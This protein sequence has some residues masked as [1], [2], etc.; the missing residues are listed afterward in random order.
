[1]LT[2][3]GPSRS[4]TDPSD[5]SDFDEFVRSRAVALGRLCWALTGDRGMGE[6]L[7][8]A[9]LERLWRRW[10]K[11][12]AAGDPWAYT[13]RIAATT[14]AS[15]R[16]RRWWHS[17]VTAP[18]EYLERLTP[19]GESLQD[20]NVDAWLSLLTVEQR[21][22]IVLRFLMDMTVEQTADI[23]RS[24]PGTI[25]S[26]TSR[27]LRRIRSLEQPSPTESSEL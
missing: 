3:V 15:W 2:V 23:L 22:V 13:C 27:A 11:V 1:V 24:P 8:Q 19:P 16:R 18:D 17:E 20:F 4:S 21:R 6:D 12:S 9:T 7:A 26:H 25:K 5:P 14:N 10:P